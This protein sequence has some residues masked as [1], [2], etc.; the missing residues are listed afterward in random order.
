MNSSLEKEVSVSKRELE[1]VLGVR[2]NLTCCLEK[3]TKRVK[4]AKETQGP[5]MELLKES[6]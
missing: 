1:E 2:V 5:W 3:R 4:R 6:G